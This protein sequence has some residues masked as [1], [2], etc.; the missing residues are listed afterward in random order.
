MKY[1]A[2]QKTLPS[3]RETL[4]CCTEL[5][6]LTKART[7]SPLADVLAARGSGGVLAAYAS[8]PFQPSR[9]CSVHMCM[10]QPPRHQAG[11]LQREA[12]EVTSLGVGRRR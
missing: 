2:S 12:P 3:D 6:V 5:T 9:A 10:A 1:T 8:V 11:R 4:P 7:S